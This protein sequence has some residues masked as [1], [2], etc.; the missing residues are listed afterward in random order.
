MSA[1]SSGE[2]RTVYRSKADVAYQAI[3]AAILDGSL[4]AGSSL[5]Q[6]QLAVDL[7][8]STT[9]LREA[10]RRLENEAFVNMPPHRDAVV[11]PLEAEELLALYEVRMTLDGLA[12]RLAA[13]RYDDEDREQMTAAAD[14]LSAD[15]DDDPVAANRALHASIYQASHNPVLIAQLDSLWDRSDRYR[16][17]ISGIA[18]QPQVVESHRELVETVLSRDGEAAERK[19]LAHIAEGLESVERAIANGDAGA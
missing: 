7:G 14:A 19:M 17:A 1:A 4:P 9:P 2:A 11:A 3:R 5:N 15:G 10:L 18:R 6:E 12:A 13:G 16:R 8:V